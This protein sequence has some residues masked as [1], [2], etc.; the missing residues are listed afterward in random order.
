[1]MQILAG[2][3]TYLLL[4]IYCHRQFKERVSIKP[5]RQ[6]RITIQNELRAVIFD[7]PPYSKFKEQQLQRVDTKS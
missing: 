5:V 3:I 7:K 6:L 1:M 2:L 4:A